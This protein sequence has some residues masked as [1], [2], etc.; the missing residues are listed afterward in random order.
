NTNLPEA[1][2]QFNNNYI[3]SSG[4]GH[5][6]T[7]SGNPTFDGAAA[8]K[9]EGTYSIKFNGTNQYT[10]IPV[11]STFLQNV[12][13]Q[14]TVSF[15]M[16]SSNNTGGRIIADIGGSDDGLVLQL[17]SSR[18]Y[19]GVASNNVRRSFYVSYTSTDWNYITLVY[20]SNTLKLYVNGVLVGSD[21]SLPFTATTTTTNG[22][23]IA[24]NNGTNAMNTGT[25][26]FSGWIDNF[27]IYNSALFQSDIV[28]LMNGQPLAHSYATTLNL[29]AVPTTPSN[30]VATGISNSKIG[31]SWNDATN[32]DSYE[33]Y[34]SSN[35]NGNYLL[36]KTLPANTTSFVDSGLFANAVFYYKVRAINVGGP[37]N[38]SNEDSAVTVNNIPQIV[39]IPTQYMRY[40]TT[41]QVNVNA[42]DV[43]PGTLNV[44]VTN[45]PAFASYVPTGNGT[46][47]INFTNPSVQATYS[48]IT[49][50]VTDAQGG[51]AV[52]SF[53]LVVNDNYNPVLGAVTGATVNEMQTAQIN[54]SATDQNVSDVLTWTFTGL[55]S[56]VTVN[57]NNGSATLNLAP[58]YADNG[59]YHVGVKVD[60][61]HNGYDTSSF[62]ITVNDV[63]PNKKTYVNFTD[64][65][66]QGAAPWNNT[67][68]VP[69]LNDN[70]A[71]L[72]DETGTVSGMGIQVMSP[73]QN[74]GNGTNVLGVNTGNNSGVYPDNVIRSAYYTTSAVQTLK[75]YGLNN[76]NTY[77]FTFFGSRAATDDRTSIYTI[78]GNSVSLNAANNSANTVK[79]NSLTP[80]PDG[81][82]TMTLQKGAS[83][84]YGYLNAM[85]IESIYDDGSA[86]AKPRNVTAQIVSGKVRLNWIDAAYNETAYEIY[87]ATS[88]TGPYALINPGGNNANLVQYDDASILGNTTYFYAIRTIN[89]HGNSPYSDTVSIATPNV[90]PVLTQV[91]DV[92]MK[93]QQVLDI[94]VT[95]TDDPA[96][97]ITLSVTGLP[98]FGSF[99]D[100]GNGTGVIHLDPGSTLGTFTGITITATDN[101][102]ASSSQSLK[103]VVTD[104]DIT[105][106]Y[107]NFNQV[108]P[109]GSPWNNFN[110]LPLANTTITGIKDDAGNTTGINV[111]LIDGWDGANNVGAT[112]GNNSG[113]FPDDVMSTAYFL[114]STNANRIRITGLSTVNTKYNLVFFASRGGVNDNR[115]TIYTYNGQSVTLNAASNTS[116]VAQLNGVVPD[117]NG[118]IEFTAQKASGSS[119]AYIGALVLQSYVD[120][121]IPL[122][123]GNL[124]VT[125]KSKSAIQLTWQDKSSNEDGFEIYR[126]TSYDGTYSLLYTTAANVTSYTDQGLPTNTLYYYKVR[127]KKLPLFYSA[128][129]AI[130][131]ASTYSYSVSIN[132]NR[133]NPQA[134]PWNNTNNAPML[135][136]VF[137]NLINDQS[138]PSGLSM[139]VAAP[140]AGDNPYGV[141]TGNNSG[142]YPDNV[143]RGS[144]WIDGGFVGAQVKISGLSQAMAY[145]FVFFGSRAGGS[146]NKVTVYTIN[147]TS[148]SLDCQDNST[149]TAQIDNVIPDENG[150]VTVTVSLGPIATYGYLG[151]LVINGYQIASGPNNGNQSGRAMLVTGNESPVNTAR[152]VPTS[153][154]TSN[155]ET[156]AALNNPNSSMILRAGVFPNPFTDQFVLSADFKVDQK[157]LVI[158]LMDATGR[159]LMSQN[160]GSASQGYWNYTMNVSNLYLK[161]G[162]YI[163][164]LYSSE[165]KAPPIA[166]FKVVKVK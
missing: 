155:A 42:A 69:A 132:F 101:H 39:A 105:S 14:K 68:K 118:V 51:T 81:S 65:S 120:N 90:S 150:E 154:N 139:T 135:Y 40:G 7:Q 15:W 91:A 26:L 17:N 43:D 149:R 36:F 97:V 80:D 78:N 163:V 41:K 113:V 29:P 96:D 86:P 88:L 122:A 37:S 123:P 112:T 30:L 94:N 95:A 121:G 59:P 164:Q 10:T 138:N 111:A 125:A 161:P 156:T 137:D 136:S 110:S 6:L 4:N 145:S 130:Q 157:N 160:A 158:R 148:V 153:N 5:T 47:T 74:I 62:N 9:K 77:N 75:I 24:S 79:I 60:D 82:L 143:M 32:E 18:L 115:N 109:A 16:K 73:W 55:P 2:W 144:W 89:S 141:N 165:A 28:N 102:S 100:N 38:Y 54:L 162:T 48:G 58:G 117:A 1:T 22:S 103:I 66:L 159:T 11:S 152:T 61:G 129:T 99:T 34:R 83:A 35:T 166:T 107:V 20:N 92:A 70:Y 147:G 127:A 108:T 93:T 133:D 98:S 53:N 31:I 128:F 25:A 142:I 87:R 67:N 71:N 56:F 151:A 63:N 126:S 106:Y 44:Q 8:N 146:G 57:T 21:N 140:F 64:G 49:I 12:Y 23:R 131:G 76:S 50:T 72:K 124:V 45:L 3:D 46:G 52:T 119:Y 116:N 33:L 13:S 134:A 27:V 114:S 85:V 19:A 84:A 104:K